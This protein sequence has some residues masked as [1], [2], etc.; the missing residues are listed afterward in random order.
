MLLHVRSTQAES[1][2]REDD[3]DKY[4]LGVLPLLLPLQISSPV[5]SQNPEADDT[6][7]NQLA[8]GLRQVA[9]QVAPIAEQFQEASHKRVQARAALRLLE[10]RVPIKAGDFVLAEA[11]IEA[12]RSAE[13]EATATLES[14][15]RSL[16]E[17]AAALTRRLQLGL[18]LRLADRGEYGNESFSPERIHEL[19]TLLNQSAGEFARQLEILEAIAVLD[20]IVAKKNSDGETPVLSRALAAQNQ[21]VNAFISIPA[22]LNVAAAPAKPGL[23]IARRQSL[24]S[25]NEVNELRH[26]T[27]EWMTDYHSNLRELVDVAKSAETTPE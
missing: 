27:V 4:F 5:A 21:V 1:A 22:D 6:E 10:A 2:P 15:R 17:V 13:T 18:S 16:H 19:V 3:C 24:A 8:L 12:A 14:L 20:K 25:P 9:E 11:T 26:K 23:Q 7:L